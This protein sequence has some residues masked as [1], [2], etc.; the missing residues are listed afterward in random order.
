LNSTTAVIRD[1]T[2]AAARKRDY[3]TQAAHP[4]GLSMIIETR[5]GVIT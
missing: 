1:V 2:V 3:F 4:D 5:A